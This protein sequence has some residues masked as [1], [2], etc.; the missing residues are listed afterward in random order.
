MADK[1]LND[2]A[3]AAVEQDPDA[4][5]HTDLASALA[6]EGRWRNWRDIVL[7]ST[8]AALGL[9]IVVLAIVNG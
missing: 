1:S 8:V 4:L 5:S 2:I 6:R 9:A 7:W 3:A